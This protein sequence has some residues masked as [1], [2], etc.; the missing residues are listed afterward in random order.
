MKKLNES[1]LTIEL[2]VAPRRRGVVLVDAARARRAARRA[3]G[4]HRVRDGVLAAGGQEG[5]EGR[6]QAGRRGLRRRG[7]GQP[8]LQLDA[9]GHL[10][11]A[12]RER[13]HQG[14]RDGV[15]DAEA[16]QE[17]REDRRRARRRA[18]AAAEAQ[19]DRGLV[20]S[21]ARRGSTR[22]TR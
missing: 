17:Y 6:A 4:P 12:G 13:G 11:P 15:P 21:R 1:C 5:R 2:F 16:A 18:D 19:A 7:R 3:G 9:Q 22:A 14:A 10:Q 20:L 8:A